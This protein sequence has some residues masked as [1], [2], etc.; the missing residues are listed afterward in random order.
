MTDRENFNYEQIILYHTEDTIVA[1]TISPLTRTI[2]RKTLS[3]YAGILTP[4]EMLS[5]PR[6]DKPG[7]E[8]IHLFKLFECRFTILNAIRHL[9]SQLH[10]HLLMAITYP[11]VFR[12]SRP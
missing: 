7:I 10:E 9:E 4:F 12:N 1:N 2:G 8:A 11:L 6:H 3:I 5:N